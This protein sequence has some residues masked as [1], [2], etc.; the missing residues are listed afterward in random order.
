MVCT[1][2][3]MMGEPTD[4][5]TMPIEISFDGQQLNGRF[6]GHCFYRVRFEWVFDCEAFN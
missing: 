1:I 4:E 6:S 2:D 5:G 3:G